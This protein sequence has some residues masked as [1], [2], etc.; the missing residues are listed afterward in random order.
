MVRGVGFTPKFTSKMMSKVG[1]KKGLKSIPI[2]MPFAILS[3]SLLYEV[4]M[5]VSKNTE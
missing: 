3:V 2:F 1:L 5:L 4:L